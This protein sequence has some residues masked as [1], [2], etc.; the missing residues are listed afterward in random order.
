MR[1]ALCG[2]LPAY[3]SLLTINLVTEGPRRCDVA[4]FYGDT[5]EKLDPRFPPFKVA[6]GVLN[7]ASCSPGHHRQHI[8]YEEACCK[9]NLP[10]LAGDRRHRLYRTLFQQI[11]NRESHILHYLLPTKQD[12]EV[13]YRL[14]SMK[15]PIV[16]ARTNR[17]KN[18]FVTYCMDYVHS[19]L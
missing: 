3:L 12:A 7:P 13:T 4:V 19:A 14:R 1:Q 15:I 18:S 9:L 2:Q 10:R 11:T 17:Y 8:P 5:A 16:R 6:Q